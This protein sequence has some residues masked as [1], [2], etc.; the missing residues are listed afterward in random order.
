MEI[1]A[2]RR[3]GRCFSFRTFFLAF[4]LSCPCLSSDVILT[5]QIMGVM[6][7][8]FIWSYRCC[9]QNA[10]SY[11]SADWTTLFEVTWLSKGS[12]CGLLTYFFTVCRNSGRS[13]I[14]TCSLLTWTSVLCWSRTACRAGRLQ[15]FDGRWRLIT[16]RKTL[17]HQYV[18]K[19]TDWLMDVLQDAA[20][21]LMSLRLFGGE[22]E[23]VRRLQCY[24]SLL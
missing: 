2:D 3:R 21:G 13:K 4:W 1:S 22:G 10:L 14:G 5:Q 20:S 18:R 6:W 11:K 24:V 16:T 17:E 9:S 15:R 7:E 8:S 19:E 12:R 23:R